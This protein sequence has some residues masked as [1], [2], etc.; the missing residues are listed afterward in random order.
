MRH[1]RTPRRRVHHLVAGVTAAGLLA[2]PGTAASSPA[3][4]RLASDGGAVRSAEVPVGPGITRLHTTTYSMVAATWRGPAPRI[5]IRPAAGGG[6]ERLPVLH[7]APDGP[8]AG[9]RS[10]TDL[11]W[12]GPQRGIEVR[13]RGRRARD[14]RLVLIEP[15]ESTPATTR[16]RAV[17][18][19]R[20]KP[21]SAPQPAMRSRKD[22]GADGSWRNGKPRYLERMK[23]VHLHHTATG[24][25][26]RRKD[27]AGIIRG[28]YRYHTQS[29]GW[30][31]IGYNFLVD[32]FGRTW[33]GRSGGPARL[34]QGAHTLGFNHASVGV[35]VIGN[36]EAKR[37]RDE[38][39]KAL[40]R[41]AAWKFDRHDRD[42]RRQVFVRSTGSDQ[43]RDG[44][45]ARL[46]AFDGHRDTNDT[47]CPGQELYELLPA[48]R[49][50]TQRR[51][52]HFS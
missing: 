32:K 28:M 34:V 4:V 27:V 9:A 46:P 26:Y 30:F 1:V 3:P 43:Y 35:A 16:G 31:D 24:N 37:P 21:S 5:S 18:P 17:A 20:A 51:I 23:Q 52:D 38:V 12:T 14:L 49:R 7:D 13:V 29:L 45:R 15:G 8:E 47:A 22:W 40:K 6:W 42:A 25:D 10:G 11:A 19:S 48:L 41:L 2:F 33:V 39:L 44:E 36:Y 50:R